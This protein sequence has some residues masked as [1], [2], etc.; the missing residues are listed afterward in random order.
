M[1]L[2]GKKKTSTDLIKGGLKAQVALLDAFEIGANAK[3]A[4]QARQAVP[5]MLAILE[6][7]CKDH[8]PTKNLAADIRQVLPLLNEMDGDDVIE[9]CRNLTIMCMAA[10]KRLEDSHAK[11]LKFK[12]QLHRR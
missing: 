6:R 5:K 8:E 11:L 2:F 1:G 3:T 4:Q 7:D 9:T 10:A 12:Q